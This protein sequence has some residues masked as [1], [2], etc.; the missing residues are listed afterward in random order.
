MLEKESAGQ[1]AQS[2]VDINLTPNGSYRNIP[3]SK[4]DVTSF[5]SSSS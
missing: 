4:A 2:A 5:T 3:T 1:E